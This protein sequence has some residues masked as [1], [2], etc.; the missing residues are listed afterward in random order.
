MICSLEKVS[1]M[2]GFIGQMG[3]KGL[4]LFLWAMQ[5]DI[6]APYPMWQM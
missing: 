1:A 4:Q 5:M 3:A 2:D 6:F